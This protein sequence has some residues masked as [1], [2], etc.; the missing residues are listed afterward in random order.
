MGAAQIAATTETGD[1]VRKTR[2]GVG[3][4]ERGGG[5]QELGR[6]EGI[7]LRATSL[8]PFADRRDRFVS[9]PGSVSYPIPTADPPVPGPQG[10][11]GRSRPDRF[12]PSSLAGRYRG[13]LRIPRS[14]EDRSAGEKFLCPTCPTPNSRS[15]TNGTR[16]L[17][18]NRPAAAWVFRGRPRPAERSAP[19][20][21]ASPASRTR[22]PR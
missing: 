15:L 21:S 17:N 22:G 16:S 20:R 2:E 3:Y 7:G 11:P 12:H 14:R 10:R 9:A 1:G 4:S 13:A 6:T 18:L 8:I 5:T 19:S